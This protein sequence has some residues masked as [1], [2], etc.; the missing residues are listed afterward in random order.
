MTEKYYTTG[1]FTLNSPR[2]F[3]QMAQMGT[4]VAYHQATNHSESFI[5]NLHKLCIVCPQISDK[6]SQCVC[7]S[8][9]LSITCDTGV[10]HTAHTFHNRCSYRGNIIFFQGYDY[11][12]YFCGARSW[13]LTSLLLFSL[14]LAFRRLCRR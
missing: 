13:L 4:G 12:H 10:L 1:F 8:P 3:T 5:T 2:E 9:L 7:I 11:H 6:V 14:C